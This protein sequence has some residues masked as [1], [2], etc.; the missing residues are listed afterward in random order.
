[1]PALAAS[2]ACNVHS[3]HHLLASRNIPPCTFFLIA[4][5]R[6]RST[7]AN[8]TKH[9]PSA[10]TGRS[11][12]HGRAAAGGVPTAQPRRD[13]R[14][15][16]RTHPPGAA[17][18]D[19]R[20]PARLGFHGRAGA[21]G[22]QQLVRAVRQCTARMVVSPSSHR[23]LHPHGNFSGLKSSCSSRQKKSCFARGWGGEAHGDTCSVRHRC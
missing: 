9:L 11:S 4:H 3:R 12:G 13:G 19:P 8:N 10:M 17:A 5:L 21:R 2:F 20:Q 14:T 22:R 23:N 18:H 7:S 1:M 6:S 16:A 15:P